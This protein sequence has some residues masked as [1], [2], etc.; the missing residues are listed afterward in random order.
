M[1]LKASCPQNI[2]LVPTLDI[3]VIW[4]T[5]LLRPEMYRSDCLRLF[6]QVIDHS[7]LTKDVEQFLKDQAFIDTCRLYEQKYGEQYCPLPSAP[8]SENRTPKYVHPLFCSLKCLIPIYSYWDHTHF[9]FE[10]KSL[11]NVH[12]NPFSFTE[13]DVILDGNWLTLCKRFMTEMKSKVSMRHYYNNNPGKIDLGTGAIRRLKKSYE[14]FLYMAA[15]YPPTE[16]YT[17]THPTYAV[18]IFKS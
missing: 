11:A 7:L 3:E 6:R 13:A 14:R 2:L 1:Q 4:Q 16:G 15:K 17:F 12:E 9:Q 5:H 10:S 8:L 18:S